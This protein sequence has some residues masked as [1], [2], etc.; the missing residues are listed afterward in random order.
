MIDMMKRLAELDATNPRVMSTVPTLNKA[1]SI[2]ESQIDECGMMPEMGMP[3]DRPTT[4]ATINMTAGSAAELGDLL[5]DIVS[6]A[7]MSKP[8][9]VS[10]M[11]LSAP[12]PAALEPAG[13]GMGPPEPKSAADSMR[14]VID[15]LN[16]A[17]DEVSKDAGDVDGDGDH[18][19]DDH[20]MEKKD[21]VDEYDN[22]P[23][24]KVAGMGAA[25]PSGNDMHKEKKQF[26][27]AQ[28]GDNAMSTF[29]GLMAEYRKFLSEEQGMPGQADGSSLRSAVLDVLQS[30]YNGALEGEEMIDDIADELGDYFDDVKQSGD[31][32]LIRAYRLVREKGADAEGNPNLMA[33]IVG[34]A[35][36]ML[37]QDAGTGVTEYNFM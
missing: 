14:S 3:M 31:R 5:K 2:K 15:K 13:D 30:I 32:T 33:R 25:V 7:G 34:Q 37:T 29:E 6:L 21:K 8:D 36:K 23:E 11:P 18:D 19:M 20:D 4:P 12:A 10:A 9:P 28:P 35:I 16:P 27:A 1:S 22:T 26:P 24:P 17:D